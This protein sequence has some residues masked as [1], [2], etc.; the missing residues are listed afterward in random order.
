[1]G[2]AGGD[3]EGLARVTSHVAILLA[4]LLLDR[5]LGEPKWL[6]D[7]VPHPAVLMGRAVGWLEARLNAGAPEARRMKGAAA[8]LILCAGAIL[9]GR[10]IASLPLGPL[11]EMLGCAILLAHKSL[12][13][14]VR[15]VAAGLRESLNAGR[16]A[17]SQIVGRDPERL[18][19]AGVARAAIESAAE[20]FSDG[21][22]APAFWLLIGGLPGVLFYKVV[23]TADSM[24]GHRTERYAEFGWAAARLDDALNW[25]PARIAGALICLAGSGRA[26]W[27]VMRRD[28][29][30]HR[31]PNA[32]WPEAAAAASLGLSLAGPRTYGGKTTDDAPLNPEGRRDA[33]A[34]DI[35]LAVALIQRAWLGLAVAAGVGT[36][37]AI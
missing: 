12:I 26:A 19:E 14:H 4:A 11:W 30:L 36:L 8:V 16:K 9:A 37:I 21:V 22:V 35:D 27:T 5:A 33:T 24:I 18:D 28:A 31:S 7:R 15:A 20:N 3:A 6:W 1:L 2:A 23:N 13:D 34:A 25:I 32:G 17:V 10:L 29:R